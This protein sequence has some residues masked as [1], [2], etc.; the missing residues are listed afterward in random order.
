MML[1]AEEVGIG[2]EK[3][4]DGDEFIYTMT[5]WNSSL[6]QEFLEKSSSKVEE[7]CI[8]SI[9][10]LNDTAPQNWEKYFT[11]LKTTFMEKSSVAVPSQNESIADERKFGTAQP[12][13]EETEVGEEAAAPKM[14]N[15][16]GILY[17]A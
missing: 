14:T 9:H 13:K 17:I 6:K 1:E 4:Q 3:S 5:F 2:K 10:A 8:V 7:E 15:W 11:S 12:I 16:G